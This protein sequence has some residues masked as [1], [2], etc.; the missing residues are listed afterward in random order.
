MLKFMHFNNTGAV[1]VVIVWE[2]V[3]RL[4]EVYS[5]LLFVIIFFSDR[6]QVRGFLWVLRFLPPIKLTVTI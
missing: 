4:G 2:F 5:I 3:F 6:Q 1:V